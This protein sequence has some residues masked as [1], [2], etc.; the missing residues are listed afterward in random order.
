MHL[1]P[2][3]QQILEVLRQQAADG[4]PAAAPAAGATAK[5]PSVEKTRKPP[6]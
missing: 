6:R 1:T 3:Q 4:A 5:R 2:R